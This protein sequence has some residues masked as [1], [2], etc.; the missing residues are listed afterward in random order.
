MIGNWNY[1]TG[2]R[3]SAVAR[4][5]IK[6]GKGDII[7]NGKPV[8]DYFARETSLMMVRQPLEL[9]NHGATFDIKV[10][11][12]GGGETGQAGA[13]R[14]GITRALIDYDATLK[15]TLSK[16]GLVTRDAREVER[17]KVGLHKARRRKQFSKR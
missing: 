13:V 3:K 15:P 16:A 14:H 2:R 4:V 10:N 7:V 8:A 9:T 5:F 12:V 6:S 1:G 11:V 17:K